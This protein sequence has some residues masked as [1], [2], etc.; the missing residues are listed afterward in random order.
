MASSSLSLRM[1]GMEYLFSK[2]MK[3]ADFS[4]LKNLP[5]QDYWSCSSLRY[6]CRSSRLRESFSWNYSSSIAF[7]L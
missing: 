2:L 4:N 1:P 5:Q 7:I 3:A 6:I